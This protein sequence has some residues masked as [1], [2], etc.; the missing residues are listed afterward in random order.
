MKHPYFDFDSNDQVRQRVCFIPSRKEN[1]IQQA[2]KNRNINKHYHHET[3]DKNSLTGPDSKA[4]QIFPFKLFF[5][6][7]SQPCK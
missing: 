7:Q 2:N 3:T 6:V 4:F 1:D 5:Y